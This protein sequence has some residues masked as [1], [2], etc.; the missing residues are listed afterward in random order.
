MTNLAVSLD[1]WSFISTQ[2]RLSVYADPWRV[3]RFIVQDTWET[4]RPLFPPQ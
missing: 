2:V 4:F 3:I 1:F